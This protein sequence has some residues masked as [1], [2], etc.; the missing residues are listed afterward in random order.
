MKVLVI[1]GGGREHAL[2]W[3]LQQSPRVKQVFCAPGN[4]GIARCATCVDISAENIAGLLDF[5]RREKIDITFVGPE[6][7]LTKGIVDLFNAAGL[8]VFGPVARAAAIEG[9]KAWAKELMTRYNIPTAR[10][11][12]FDRADAAREY[13]SKNGIP[14]V[15]KADGLAAGKGVVVCTVVEQALQAVEDMM[16][17]KV[18]GSAGERVVIEE[19]LEGEEVSILAFTDGK[20]VTPMLSAQDHKQVFDGDRGPNTGGMGAYAPA[21]VC[22]PEVYRA[23]REQI[24]IPMVRALAAEGCPYRGV[25]YAGLMIT[26]D[27]PRVLE[28]NVRFGD[29]EA[30]P[31][32]MLLKT[33]LVDICEAIFAGRLSS[34]DIKWEQ[35]A[36]VC[37]TLA[38][39]GYPGRYSTGYVIKGLEDLPDDIQVF[40]A[41]T[42][43]KEG[44]L[45]TSGGRVLGVTAVAAN[46]AEAIAR[47][48]AGAEKISFENM[49]YRR[50]I[51]Q[52]ALRKEG[53]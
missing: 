17:K 21:P 25:L 40:H 41:G 22:T 47:A 31:L 44:Q 52:K 23:A 24:L 20:T 49:H 13:L 32:L 43:F 15:V 2:V 9:S 37:V 8:A 45:V 16:E 50:D 10:Y 7:P 53:F 34:L 14:C 29:P 26:S 27:G 3:K 46:I 6:V 38:S 28:F 30:Q 4:A 19:C 39:G 1:G 11:A 36:A 51:G 42:A 5:A 48:Y 12:V 18:F 35:G 33:D